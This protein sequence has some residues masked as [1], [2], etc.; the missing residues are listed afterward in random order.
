[1]MKNDLGWSVPL[2]IMDANYHELEEVILESPSVRKV[3][4]LS[5]ILRSLGFTLHEDVFSLDRSDDVAAWQSDSIV[6]VQL[7]FNERETFNLKGK[8]NSIRLQYYLATLPVE[9]GSI[10]LDTVHK[11]AQ[12]LNLPMR[13]RGEVVSVE[14]LRAIFDRY[15]KELVN[16]LGESPGSEGLAIMI[17][18]AYH[19]R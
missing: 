15:S 12:A 1:M 18:E 9:L 13:F 4:E 16:D 19:R 8:W 11:I 6:E 10:F 3:P 5:K 2:Q 17:H 14:Q 7:V